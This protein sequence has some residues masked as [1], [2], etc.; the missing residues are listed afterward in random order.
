MSCHNT[1]HSQHLWL[2]K[3]KHQ[4]PKVQPV[5]QKPSHNIQ[6]QLANAMP[7]LRDV[8]LQPKQAA[9]VLETLMLA[10]QGRLN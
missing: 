2:G 5:G 6:E 3:S 1:H 7:T 9:L 8:L 4:Q 10:T